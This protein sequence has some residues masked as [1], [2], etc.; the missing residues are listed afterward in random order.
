MLCEIIL[1]TR[2]I[3]CAFSCYTLEHAAN[4]CNQIFTP[5]QKILCLYDIFSMLIVIFK[6]TLLLIVRPP[7]CFEQSTI[8]NS[9]GIHLVYAMNLDYFY[10]IV[11]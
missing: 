10:H 6:S 7:I 4:F 9:S 5:F 11:M 2:A 8:N 1:L 3:I